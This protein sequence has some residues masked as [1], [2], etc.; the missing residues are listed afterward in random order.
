[1]RIAAFLEDEDILQPTDQVRDLQMNP[2]L[3]VEFAASELQLTWRPTNEML[4]AWVGKPLGDY[5]LAADGRWPIEVI[6]WLD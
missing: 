4:H 3:G 1:M 5:R 6:L 2:F